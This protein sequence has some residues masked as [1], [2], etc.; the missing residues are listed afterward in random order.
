MH[1]Y[2]ELNVW[3]KA[4]IF[5]KEVYL[6]AG[7]F[8]KEEKYGLASQ[9]QRAAVSIPSNIAEGAGRESPKEF[10]YFLNVALA[11]SF[12][13]ETQLILAFDLSYI[14]ENALNQ[15]LKNVQEIQKM[16]TGLMKSLKTPKGK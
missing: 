13:V 14:S 1:N 3:K 4:R 5:V 2:K 8:P 7:D 11:S 6:L 10:H 15:A 9:I 12:E 16:L